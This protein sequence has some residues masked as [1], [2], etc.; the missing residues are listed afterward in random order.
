MYSSEMI[1]DETVKIDTLLKNSPLTV[2]VLKRHNKKKHDQEH[3]EEFSNHDEL[4]KF[5]GVGTELFT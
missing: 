3:I 2:S 5:G 4:Y 1:K